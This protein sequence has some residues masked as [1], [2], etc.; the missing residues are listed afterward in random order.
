MNEPIQIGSVEFTHAKHLAR[1]AE[2]EKP[3]K[4]RLAELERTLKQLVGEERFQELNAIAQEAGPAK[5]RY[6]RLSALPSQWNV[7]IER[8]ALIEFSQL[9]H[10]KVRVDQLLNLQCT[11]CHAYHSGH[12]SGDA[13]KPQHHFSVDTSTCFTCHFNNEGFNTGT[14]RCLL[15]HDPP[16]QEIV[17]H[18][19]LSPDAGEKLQAPELAAAPIKMNHADIMAK[20][21]DCL[22][23]HADVARGDATV[24]RRDCERC[25]D[26][27][28]FFEDWKEPFT[29]EQVT[30]YH[31]AHIH[32]Q[33]A[34][35][36]DCHSEIKHSLI[37]GEGAR[38]PAFL[39]SAM[40]D[41]S[42]CHTNPHVE[43][44]KLLTGQGGQGV[45]TSD[46]NPMFGARTNCF[47]CHT[48]SSAHAESEAAMRGAAQ[49]CVACHA[50]RYADQFEKWKAGVELTLADA[51]QS[52]DEARKLF[53]EKTAASA[54]ARQKASEL[55]KVAEADLRLVKAGNGVHNVTYALEL[56]DSVTAHS[57]QAADALSAE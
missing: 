57:Q 56:L 27:P 18:E 5:Q 31:E 39:A 48:E 26:Q 53:D 15:C 28:R 6:D 36:L 51:E 22:A 2:Q 43:Q 42:H 54:E 23:C 4:D 20:N 41:C 32:Q 10:R 45:P 30:K 3:N 55:L 52:F 47:G 49:T 16:Q 9:H 40:S 1:S 8:G 11:N 34:K 17:V 29:L 44:L 21:V 19:A 13:A 7:D 38:D 25:H 35:C 12:E 37:R 46:P 14:N 33:R 50:E 24:S